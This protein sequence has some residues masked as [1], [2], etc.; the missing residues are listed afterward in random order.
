MV[1]VTRVMRMAR[2]LPDPADTLTMTMEHC[3]GQGHGN[4]PSWWLHWGVGGGRPDA[5]DAKGEAEASAP[6][7]LP[8]WRPPPGSLT[9]P[10][11]HPGGFVTR[12]PG[13]FRP[14]RLTEPY[15]I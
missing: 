9:P 14:G 3:R 6:A 5:C 4:V 11:P 8:H 15:E 7:G 12:P 10:E 1:R 13:G 2:V